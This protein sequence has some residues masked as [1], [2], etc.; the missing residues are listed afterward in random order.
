M[1]T[2]LA[3]SMIVY[4][5]V[6]FGI[7]L[8]ARKNIATS[9]DF[10]VAGRRLP[11]SVSTATL[12]ATWFGAG[13]LMESANTVHESGLGETA[14]EPI[15]PGLCLIITGIFFARKLWDAKIL[16]LNDLYRER[17]GRKTELLST[18]YTIS[19]LPWI[20]T[21]FK[22]SAGILSLFFE[23]PQTQGIAIIA[24]VALVYTLLGGM[25]SVS[26][27]DF[28]QIGLVTIGLC[29]L[30]WN[31]YTELGGQ[32]GVASALE[33]VDP[34]QLRIVPRESV[35][36]FCAWLGLFLSGTIGL[37]ASQDL[38]QRVFASK[39]AR[40]AQMS[41]V[42]AGGC[43][44]VLG[45]LAAGLGLAARFLLDEGADD[46]VPALGA[47][48]L[49]E[50]LA[51]VFVLCIVSTIL[52]SLDSAILAP[53]SV[54]AQNLLRHVVGERISVLTLTR[55]AM[56]AVTGASVF[57]ALSEAKAFELLGSS[58]AMGIAPFVIL[59]FAL[60]KR[61]TYPAP[62]FLTLLT[63]LSVWTCEQNF[64]WKP[65]LSWE[66]VSVVSCFGVYLVAHEVA[67]RRS[68]RPPQEHGAKTHGAK[69]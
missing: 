15:G 46:V 54:L 34:K 37:I 51:V 29:L 55:L 56:V 59:C 22:A 45:S 44:L 16:T 7:S 5:V 40:A 4:T 53:S 58:Y 21:Q 12:L 32:N 57:I 67:K 6:L 49:S 63:G 48:Y 38:M 31:V 13:T 62:A 17:F 27:T 61:R 39:S 64:S 28:L 18:A 2:T 14:L 1:E 65:P 10:V 8:W 35:S 41:C 3:I 43:Y 69:T 24:T 19:F 20:A 68:G 33:T 11:F 26:I 50:G 60:S 23:I 66:V 36:E 52:S 42:V 25:W 47:K 30:S 9:E